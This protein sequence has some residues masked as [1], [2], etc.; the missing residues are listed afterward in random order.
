MAT[1]PEFRRLSIQFP[2][3]RHIFR[4]KFGVFPLEWIRHVGVYRE[5]NDII[6]HE[7]IVAEFQPI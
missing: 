1:W 2:D 4:L 6:S 5:R 7:I 3:K